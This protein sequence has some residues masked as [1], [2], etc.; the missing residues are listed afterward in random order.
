MFLCTFSKLISMTF[1]SKT[2]WV[3][4]DSPQDVH[5][6]VNLFLFFPSKHSLTIAIYHLI[7]TRVVVNPDAI[8]DPSEAPNLREDQVGTNNDVIEELAREVVIEVADDITGS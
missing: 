1:R 5:C 7:D 2:G 8:V 4:V 3:V 6:V